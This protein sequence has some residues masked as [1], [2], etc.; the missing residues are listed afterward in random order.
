MTRSYRV[1]YTAAWKWTQALRVEGPR[2]L[3]EAD[4]RGPAP[5][6]SEEQ[7]GRPSRIREGGAPGPGAA[8]VGPLL[9]PQ[10]R[11]ASE[12]ARLRWNVSPTI[13]KDPPTLPAGLLP[14]WGVT[15]VCVF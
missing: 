13:S 12:S 8:T 14:A 15:Y 6:L 3:L 4:G 1:A 7:R 5:G 9:P 10:S 2:R 11:I